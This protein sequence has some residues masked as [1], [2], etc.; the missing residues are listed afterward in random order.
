MLAFKFHR[1]LNV[2]RVVQ[3]DAAII[4]RDARGIR[5]GRRLGYF[6]IHELSTHICAIYKKY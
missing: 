4:K 3:E 2:E 1:N 6:S 5:F